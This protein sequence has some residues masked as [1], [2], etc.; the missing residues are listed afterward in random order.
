MRLAQRIKKL[1]GTLGRWKEPSVKAP[2]IER[3][4]EEWA[5]W[6]G[7]FLWWPKGA[8]MDHWPGYFA[9]A[10]QASAEHSD[11]PLAAWR[12]AARLAWQQ[13][14]RDYHVGLRPYALAVWLRWKPDIL[15]HRRTHGEWLWD[16]PPRLH[17]MTREEFARQTLQ[18]K[19][20]LLLRESGEGHWSKA[21]V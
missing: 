6:I 10:G 3:T 5:D 2:E 17:T 20:T 11:N 19:S 12:Q 14:H 4:D 8:D 13:G 9:S 7:D 16:V 15:E 21:P 1:E 18:E